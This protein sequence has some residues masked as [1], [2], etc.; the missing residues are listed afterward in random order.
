MRPIEIEHP[1]GYLVDSDGRVVQRFAN[2]ELG[3][4]DVSDVID[5]VEYVD[6]VDGHEKPVHDDYVT[7]TS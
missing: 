4:H 3:G 7:A 1:H 6:G 5:R 2:W